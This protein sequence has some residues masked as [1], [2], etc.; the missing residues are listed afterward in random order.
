[1]VEYKEI[2]H[3]DENNRRKNRPPVFYPCLLE[4]DGRIVS[5]IILAKEVQFC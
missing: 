2:F 4:V 1:M 5:Y 3:V